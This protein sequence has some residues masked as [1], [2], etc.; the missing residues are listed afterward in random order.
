[1][2]KITFEN[3]IQVSPAR[4]NEDG[5]ITPVQYEGNTPFSAHIMNLLQSKIEKSVVAVGSTQPTTNE[6][7]W[8]KKGKNIFSGELELGS[9]GDDGRLIDSENCLRSKNFIEVTA[10]TTY[11][12]SNDMNYANSLLFAYDQNFNCISKPRKSTFTTPTNC[13]YIK[14]RSASG[15]TENDLNVKYMLEQGTTATSYESYIEK[16]IYVKNDNG[17]FEKFVNV[18][19]L[20]KSDTGWIDMTQYINTTYFRARPNYEPKARRIG[21]VVYWQGEVYCH[22]SLNTNSAEILKEIPTS[23][24]PN[25]QHSVS[26]FPFAYG[27]NGEPYNIFIDANKTINISQKNNI[28][29]QDEVYGY[30]LGNLNGYLV[31]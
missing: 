5:T 8:I 22:T 25:Y 30:Q 23:F 12:L 24:C 20:E 2:D 13:K 27:G 31:D 4:V 21:N 18:S 1:M 10:D 9:I 7:F 15:N 19:E 3:G 16:E 6:K 26:G 29:V 14:F 17:V 11:T 28:D